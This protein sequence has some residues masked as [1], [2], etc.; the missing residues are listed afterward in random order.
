MGS[1][2]GHPNYQPKHQ[3]HVADFYIDRW[4]VTNIEY[5]KFIDVTGYPVPNYQVSWCET[6][7]YNWNPQT[8]LYPEG[9]ADHP[10]VLITWDDAL[11]YAAWAGKRLPTEAEWERTARGP[12]GW[13]YPWGDDFISGRCNS[14]EAGLAGTSPV[15]QFSPFGDTLEGVVDMVGN[16]WEWTGSLYYPYPYNPH[17]GRESHEASGFRV[18]RGASWMN[19]AHVTNCLSRLDGDFRFYNNVGFRCAVSLDS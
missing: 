15:G 4:P 19:D 14:K 17:D 12:E 1:N 11:A 6:E 13:R 8:R 18:L 2:D 16:V 9:K 3:V 5:K 10:V 7:G